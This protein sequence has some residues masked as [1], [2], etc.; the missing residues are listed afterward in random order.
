MKKILILGIC[1]LCLMAADASVILSNQMQQVPQNAVI[2]TD[3]T[4]LDS[5]K[6][7]EEDQALAEIIRTDDI[8]KLQY[9]CV[10]PGFSLNYRVKTTDDSYLFSAAQIPL[11]HYAAMSGSIK[12][13]KYLLINGA[14]PRA[15]VNFR[16]NSELRIDFDLDCVAF[17]MLANGTAEIVR[18]L[19]WQGSDIFNNPGAWWAAALNNQDMFFDWLSEHSPIRD[20][21]EYQCLE[22]ALIGM[23]MG[24]HPERLDILIQSVD[25]KTL[26]QN[27]GPNELHL[28]DL[29]FVAAEYDQDKIAAGL[30]AKGSN[31]NAQW[32]VHSGYY[33]ILINPL[34]VA[35]KHNSKRIGK[36]LISEGANIN[37][38][39]DDHGHTGNGNT[40]LH[41]AAKYDSRDIGEL[42]ISKGANINATDKFGRTP[43]HIAA[44]NNGK[45]IGEILISKGAGVNAQD[46][47]G[48]TP[49]HSAAYLGQKDIAEILVTKGADINAQD[50]EG[51]TPLHLAAWYFRDPECNDIKYTIGCFLISK[52]A[53]INAKDKGGD[54]PL[55]DAAMT[56]ARN[57]GEILI[58]KGASI[59]VKNNIGNAP[60]HYAA[61]KNADD[62][63][64][65]VGELLISKGADM[66]VKNNNGETPLHM[67]LKESSQGLAKIL[68][69]KGAD[70]NVQ[71][72]NGK[73]PLFYAKKYKLQEIINLLLLHGAIE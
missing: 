1:S 39:D 18:L 46:K 73:T 57:I 2:A 45:D 65:Y 61:F 53:N 52:G 11:I 58:S 40:T 42:L 56:G 70:L 6:F 21:S 31:V 12:C 51:K 33:G 19:E 62:T 24:N 36:L 7:R 14:N 8:D 30:I 5:I 20:G 35:A 54:T 72:N 37:A 34:H 16:P 29:L 15:L 22:A 49:L 23:M 68:I 43:L 3:P 25:W 9:I 48:K 32:S 64:T 55:H 10:S 63:S 44:M 13:F 27:A 60:L 59:N 69:S 66:N 71:D 4:M 50:K 41:Y 67:A 38:R 47:E 26:M 17:S 28:N